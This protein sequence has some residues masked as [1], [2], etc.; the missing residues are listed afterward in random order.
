MMKRRQAVGRSVSQ[1]L[2]RYFLYFC[3]QGFE[4][5][6]GYLPTLYLPTILREVNAHIFKTSYDTISTNLCVL[7]L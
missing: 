4:K 7:R 2:S 6:L 3:M 5:N 1:S